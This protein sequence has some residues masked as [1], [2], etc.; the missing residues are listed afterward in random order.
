MY[1]TRMLQPIEGFMW[2]HIKPILQVILLATAMLVSS[3][4]EA[5]SENKMSR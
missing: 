3:L 2:R 1:T 4:Y 5:V